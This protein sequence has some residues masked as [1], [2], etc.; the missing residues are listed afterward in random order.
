[1][2]LN[3]PY[4]AIKLNE[5]DLVLDG[6]SLLAYL[7]QAGNTSVYSTLGGLGRSKQNFAVGGQETSQMIA[8]AATQIDP[9][10]AANKILIAWELTNSLYF[11]KTV[12][13]ACAEFEAYC[14]ARKTA[15]WK[16]VVLT[17]LPRNQTPTIGT[18]EQYNINL[19]AVNNW[20]INNYKGFSNALVD[21][22]RVPELNNASDTNIFYDGIHLSALGYSYLIP[23]INRGIAKIKK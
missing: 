14:S 10:Y 16:I 9:E 13:Q 19:L 23:E 1:M 2:R 3:R 7:L 6:N 5:V 21:V 12:S 22:R 11:G 4:R 17:T 18:V 15:G 20:L 8:D